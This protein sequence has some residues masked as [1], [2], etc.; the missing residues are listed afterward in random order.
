M[1]FFV[2][3]FIAHCVNFVVNKQNAGRC[4]M[5]SEKL[6]FFIISLTLNMCLVLIDIDITLHVVII[7]YLFLTNKKG[8]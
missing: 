1:I 6:E 7:S 8:T 3:C 4:S 5:R 2:L